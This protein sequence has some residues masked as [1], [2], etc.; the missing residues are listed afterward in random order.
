[1]ERMRVLKNYFGLLGNQRNSMKCI[2]LS[3]YCNSYSDTLFSTRSEQLRPSS[4]QPQKS[5]SQNSLSN[6]QLIT[7]LLKQHKMKSADSLT[8]RV[9]T[10]T[11]EPDGKS[12][13]ELVTLNQAIRKA[14]DMKR[15][16]VSVDT[17]QDVPVLRITSLQSL[18]Y[19]QTK[20]NSDNKKKNKSLPA[21]EVRFQTRIE[22]NDFLRKVDLI[23][24]Y[25]EKGHN[26]LVTVRATMRNAKSDPEGAQT[27]VKK[28]LEIIKGDVELTKEP[29]SNLEKTMVQ[30]QVRPCR[31]SKS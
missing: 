29:T 10:E 3:M 8:V 23:R 30:F 20:K 5:R 2:Y 7:N 4:S 15:D 26:C 14:V 16:L 22:E 21:K 18:L 12:F 17:R 25:S 11:T 1:M 13:S 28:I 6:D 19:Q 24:D 31:S 27:F 9:I